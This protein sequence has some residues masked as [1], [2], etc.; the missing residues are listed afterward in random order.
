MELQFG[1]PRLRGCALPRWE[2][3][4]GETTNN[5]RYARKTSDYSLA[6]ASYS[7]ALFGVCSKLHSFISTPATASHKFLRLWRRAR[8][9]STHPLF[10]LFPRMLTPEY[11]AQAPEMG[12]EHFAVAVHYPFARLTLLFLRL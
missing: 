8:L 7:G 11:T 5:L 10:P 4:F 3:L 9:P 1:V 6:R 2:L 12:R